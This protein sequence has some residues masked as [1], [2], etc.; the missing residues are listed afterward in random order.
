[1]ST[2]RRTDVSERGVRD[3]PIHR[4]V[5]HEENTICKN[6]VCK[7]FINTQRLFRNSFAATKILS[8]LHKLTSNRDISQK[9]SLYKWGWKTDNVKSKMFKTNDWWRSMRSKKHFERV[10]QPGENMIH[11]TCL[12]SFKNKLLNKMSSAL[13]LLCGGQKRSFWK[14]NISVLKAWFFLATWPHLYQLY[15]TL[16]MVPI[17]WK[18]HFYKKTNILHDK[19]V[20]SLEADRY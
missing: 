20:I 9:M 3:V 8:T 1:M 18:F 16:L 10:I 19:N 11:F 17:L 5:L 13:S 12:C 7:I 6:V 4:F 15:V 2:A 14:Q